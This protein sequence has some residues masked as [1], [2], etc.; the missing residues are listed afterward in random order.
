MF[1]LNFKYLNI[2]K[3]NNL[4]NYFNSAFGTSGRSQVIGLQV[5]SFVDQSPDDLQI[6]SESPDSNNPSLHL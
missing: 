1:F 6:V 4:K 3:N 5:C 2:P